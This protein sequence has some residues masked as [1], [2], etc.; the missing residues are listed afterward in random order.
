MEQCCPRSPLEAVLSVHCPWAVLVGTG[1]LGWDVSNKQ[2]GC[3]EVKH[4]GCAT[5]YGGL[6]ESKALPQVFFLL[7]RPEER[8]MWRTRL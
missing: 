3:S 5:S 7:E 2:S 8:R 6:M 4:P 1:K